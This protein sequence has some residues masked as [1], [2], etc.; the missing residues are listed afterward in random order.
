MMLT[1]LLRS[2]HGLVTN[3]QIGDNGLES[4]VFPWVRPALMDTLGR[5]NRGD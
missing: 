5:A 3:P 4:T 1:I 2:W